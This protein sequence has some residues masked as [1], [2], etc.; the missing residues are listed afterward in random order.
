MLF[1]SALVES[2]ARAGENGEI[3][4][5][6]LGR[7]SPLPGSEWQAAQGDAYGEAATPQTAARAR[8][9][10]RSWGRFTRNFIVQG[11]AAEWALCWMAG[12]R[13]RLWSLAEG[14]ALDRPHLVF[15]LHDEVI[16]HTPA[17]L[18][19]QVVLEVRAAASTRA[20]ACGNALVSAGIS[21]PLSPDVAP[22]M[23]PSIAIF[24]CARVLTAPLATIPS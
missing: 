12:L 4:T 22:Y 6:R 23:A 18:A 5:T 20:I 11:T 16:V 8:G 24:A 9:A 17:R 2:A 14:Q 3:V 13:G 7:S 21:R 1:R 19:E 15:F 10:A